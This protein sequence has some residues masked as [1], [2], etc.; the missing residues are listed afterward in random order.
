MSTRAEDVVE[1]LIVASTHAYLLIFT[2]KGRV[3]WL[4]IYEY[5]RCRDHR[6]RKT[7]F[8]PDRSCSRMNRP[9]R[10]CR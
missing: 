6:Q 2:N 7:R 4:K 10:F 3:Y 5:S 9:R 1:H 8:R